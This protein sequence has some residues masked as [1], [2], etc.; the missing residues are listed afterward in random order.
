MIPMYLSTPY[1]FWSGA[2]SERMKQSTQTANQHKAK[3]FSLSE[4]LIAMALM[5]FVALLITNFLVKSNATTSTVSMR[6]KEVNEV[7]ALIQDLYADLRQGVYISDNSHRRRLEYTT[8]DATGA[9]V[10]KIY[11]LTASGSNYYLEL[12]LDGGTSWGSPYRLAA[13]ASKY[14]L[15]GTPLFLYSHNS[16]N[17]TEFTDTNSNGVWATGE[18]AAYTACG[19][20]SITAPV[21]DKP[22]QATKV[23]LHNFSFTTGLG[24]PEAIR[25][26][27]G[28]IFINAP[29]GPVR[30]Q[31]SVA[32]PGVKDPPAQLSFSTSNASNAMFPSG[33][34]VS[35]IVWDPYH[36]RLIIGADAGGTA[37]G[38]LYQLERNGIQI[39]EPLL[40]VNGAAGA[41]SLAIDNGGQSV[42]AIYFD[43]TASLYYVNQYSLSA[44]PPITPIST[45]TLG[46]SPDHRRAIAV[47]PNT[48]TTLFVACNDSG[49]LK[50]LEYYKTNPGTR[51]GSEW[52]LPAA[53][54]SGSE[55]GGMFIE[56]TSG[57]FFILR[58]NV[59][60][61]GGS[62]YLDVY[63]IARSG[64]IATTANFSINVTDMDSTNTTTGV[65][66]YWQMTYD[67][68]TNHI[69]L[70]DSSKSKVYE[71][72]PP[73]IISPR[74]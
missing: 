43:S 73:K 6:Y 70:S 1:K 16:N 46:A 64:A 53:F 72:V 24:T 55:I 68:A 45:L 28:D 8:Y 74:S 20:T 26:L 12:S 40:F 48:P 23:I 57:D 69:F 36:E 61:S 42:Y 41:R 18:G 38:R 15:T 5:G 11:R 3:G 32:S 62:K 22:S 29:Q 34:S 49:T 33:F 39:N 27:P 14:L 54:T 66:G 44:T 56:P 51:T 31:I 58:N 13:S 37:S 50:I 59:Y 63:R 67:P 17:C 60:T 71:V 10:K 7:H 9:A 35:G 21:L 52:N 2:R 25:N 19:S 47:D 30:S 65:S 4:I